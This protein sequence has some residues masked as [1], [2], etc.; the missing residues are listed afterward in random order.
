[1]PDNRHNVSLDTDKQSLTNGKPFY[2]YYDQVCALSQGFINRNFEEIFEILGDE[3]KT[4][5]L[6]WFEGDI[7]QGKIRARM[8]APQI[9][10]DFDNVSDPT[11]YYKLRFKSGLLVISSSDSG[12]DLSGW[13]ITV[14]ANLAE[15][16]KRAA[17]EAKIAL[18][19]LKKTHEFLQ[20]LSVE[21]ATTPSNDASNLASMKPGEYSLHRLFAAINSAKWG[22]P[23]S[24][25]ST[26]PGPDGKRIRLDDWAGLNQ[27]NQAK[28]DKLKSV[29]Q[30]WAAAHRVSAFF[31][32]GL[33][34]RPPQPESNPLPSFVPKYLYIQ[35]Y[36]YWNEQEI[37]TYRSPGKEFPLKGIVGRDNNCLV[38]CEVCE[39]KVHHADRELPSLKRLPFTANL[40]EPDAGGRGGFDGSFI[41]G[42]RLFLHEHILPILQDLCRAWQVIPLRP[43]MRVDNEGNAIFN[44]RF[45]FGEMPKDV[46]DR[47]RLP[48]PSVNRG[49]CTND[50][51]KFKFVEPG[52]YQWSDRIIAPGSRSDPN[53]KYTHPYN[54][55]KLG[56]IYREYDISAKMDVTVTW[57]P[58]SS[59]FKIVGTMEYQ[60]WE[61]YC[62]NKNFN[63]NYYW[64]KT[65]T[66]GSWSVG[67]ELERTEQAKQN[68]L[69]KNGV[70]QPR[71]IGHVSD[72]SYLP[73]DLKFTQGTQ[74]LL[75]DTH[76][77]ITKSMGS[78][79]ESALASL[80]KA[81][82]ERSANARPLTYPGAGE[83]DFGR[84]ML[85]ARGDLVADIRY[86][87]P[88][89]S[90]ISVRPPGLMKYEKP[91]DVISKPI[92]GDPPPPVDKD[93]K[94]PH[95][96][97][98]GSLTPV[99]GKD[100]RQRFRVVATNV[101]SNKE[102]VKSSAFGFKCLVVTFVP[103]ERSGYKTLF[104]EKNPLKWGDA[105]AVIKPPSEPKKP[106]PTETEPKPDAGTD[107]E[108][109][110]ETPIAAPKPGMDTSID[111]ETG[112]GAAAGAVDQ[113]QT[114]APASENDETTTED[115]GSAATTSQATKPAVTK[116]PVVKSPVTKLPVTKL[117]VTKL[118][119]TKLPVTKLPVTK[120]PVTKPPIVKPPVVKPVI[121]PP[122]ANT[123]SIKTSNM[124]NTALR[125]R[126][127]EE[128]GAFFKVFIEPSGKDENGDALKKFRVDPSASIT[129]DLE[130]DVNN[131]NP[132]GSMPSYHVVKLTEI[133]TDPDMDVEF[134]NPDLEGN[135]DCYFCVAVGEKGMGDVVPMSKA[136]VEKEVEGGR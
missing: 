94:P 12:T 62:A 136:E 78:G 85:S 87:K 14:S 115:A 11:I 135:T 97:W 54:G 45:A 121:K 41:I 99:S 56:L 55:C 98:S 25:L 68:T 101:A 71:L 28:Y 32:L 75:W 10:L 20:P 21:S 9:L 63:E 84:P 2:E 92:H 46:D 80:N 19:E 108:K 5:P 96:V 30:N 102:L 134:G 83:L 22:L 125:V 61:A 43:E 39:S 15:M 70:I 65:Q 120:L 113:S 132:L 128:D 116:P 95:L 114:D 82:L 35:P 127:D 79:M 1:M 34:V 57:E 48:N 122:P 130:G 73:Q 67:L 3:K 107:K 51:F 36:P 27:D 49:D 6:E 81:L 13:E 104:K 118:P 18:D 58:L 90:R 40:S 131:M 112:N 129:L 110:P 103:I 31:T 105:N 52:K 26:C 66:N 88:D 117:P 4:L 133:W 47:V 16:T 53:G 17:A 38:Y 126:P 44:P 7:T 37:Q 89:G 124:S 72:G 59:R 123:W 91:K 60:H 76:E 8:D 42:H 69:D 29:I 24:E 64:G 50:F 74:Y 109:Q 23:N 33:Q 93:L 111:V 77:K 106:E 119:V 86:K 100:N